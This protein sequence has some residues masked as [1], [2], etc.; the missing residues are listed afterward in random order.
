MRPFNASLFLFAALTFTHAAALP[1]NYRRQGGSPSASASASAASS[2]A[3]SSLDFQCPPTDTDGVS[4]SGNTVDGDILTCSYDTSLGPRTCSYALENGNQ[5]IE[6]DGSM[7]GSVPPSCPLQADPSSASSSASATST[8]SASASSSSASSSRFD[9]Q[10]P[11]TDTDGVSLSGNSIEG[12]N[13]TCSYDTSMGPRT[14]NYALQN[15]GLINEQ[16][17][18]TPPPSCPPN[19]VPRDGSSSESATS[20]ASASVSS[21]TASSSLDFQC[22]ATDTDGVSLSGNSVGGEILTCSYDT[23]MGPRTCEY[24]LEDGNQVIDQSGSG[25]VVSA[26]SCP[27]HAD[28]SSGSS[29]GSDSSNSNV[30]D[31]LAAVIALLQKIADNVKSSTN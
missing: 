23:D 13:L 4:L 24:A 7:S 25:S 11:P 3:T 19:A 1:T 22:P 10:C 30:S 21:S 18:S 8:A 2:S 9:F 14:C 20:T 26:P 6:Q 12:F 5:V 29:S 15:G 17:G 27:A 31:A 28:P 16:D